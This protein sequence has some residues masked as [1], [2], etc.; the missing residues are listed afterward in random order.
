[1]DSLQTCG[2]NAQAYHSQLESDETKELLENALIR[3]DIKALVATSALGMG[4][5][6]PDLSFV[7]HYQSPE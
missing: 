4:F 2:I 5:D 3:N 1:M 7:I 6:K